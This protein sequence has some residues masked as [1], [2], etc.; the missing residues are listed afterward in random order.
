MPL[1][2]SLGKLQA[3]VAG[4]LPG[5]PFSVDNF[6]SLLTDSVGTTDGLAALGI[7][8]QLFSAWLPLILNKGV[9]QRR[10]DEARSMPRSH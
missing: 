1:P 10:L 6:Q 7:R 5:K 3:Q 9:R 2:D 4:M 8:P